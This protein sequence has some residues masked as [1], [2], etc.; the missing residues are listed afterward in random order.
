MIQSLIKDTEHGIRRLENKINDYEKFIA[1]LDSAD[2]TFD[3]LSDEEQ[4]AF[5]EVFLDYAKF[6]EETVP[7][8]RVTEIKQEL[9]EALRQPAQRGLQ[10]Q[11]ARVLDQFE[12]VQSGSLMRSLE[13]EIQALDQD[14]IP[15]NRNQLRE[16]TAQS[17]EFSQPAQQYIREKITEDPNILFQHK[18]EADHLLQLVKTVREREQTLA[19]IASSVESYEWIELPNRDFGPFPNIWLSEPLPDPGAVTAELDQLDEYWDLFLQTIGDTAPFLSTEIDNVLSD[20]ADGLVD[21]LTSLVASLETAANRV[22]RIQYLIEAKEAAQ[23]LEHQIPTEAL[24]ELSNMSADAVIS[25]REGLQE[26]VR[27]LSDIYSRWETDMTSSWRSDAQVLMNL[28]E[29]FGVPEPDVLDEVES[30]EKLAQHEPVLAVRQLNSLHAS[31]AGLREDIKDGTGLG[32]DAVDLL[33]DLIAEEDIP[34][35]RY[36]IG[37]VESLNEKI[38]LKVTID[39]SA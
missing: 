14:L 34:I 17:S 19:T 27:S 32:D 26:H 24:S 3:E 36:G 23:E 5:E 6:T 35:S 2:K 38:S 37:A 8:N 30:M 15:I 13:A 16:V 9:A 29:Q 31:L 21:P 33:L 10:E 7:E 20:P 12:V 25:D 39:E 1:W 18:S 4:N 11:T 28:S 22:G